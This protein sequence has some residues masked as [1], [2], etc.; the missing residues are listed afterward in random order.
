MDFI[1]QENSLGIFNNL[2]AYYEV[3]FYS[4]KI[5]HL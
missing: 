1:W 4:Q 3:Y 2:D 5:K